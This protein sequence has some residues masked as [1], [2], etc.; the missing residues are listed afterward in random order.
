VDWKGSKRLS[1]KGDL[2]Q[3]PSAFALL[4]SAKVAALVRLNPARVDLVER[5]ENW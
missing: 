1:I 4:L 3:Q 5:F 2:E